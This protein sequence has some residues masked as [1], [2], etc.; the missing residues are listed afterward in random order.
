[1]LHYFDI[2]QIINV[3]LGMLTATGITLFVMYLSMILA[4]VTRNDQ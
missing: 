1:M 2:T 3:S 4:S